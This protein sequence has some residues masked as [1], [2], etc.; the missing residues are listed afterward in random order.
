MLLGI[1]GSQ[2]GAQGKATSAM[3]IVGDGDHISIAVIADGMD[4]WHLS[5]A[6]AVNGQCI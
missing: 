2:Y 4:A 5:T 3:G 1:F 6:D